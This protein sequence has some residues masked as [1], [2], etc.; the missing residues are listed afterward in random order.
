MAEKFSVF[1]A[2]EG[3]YWNYIETRGK[4]PDCFYMNEDMSFM[5]Y[6]EVMMESIQKLEWDEIKR[7]ENLTYRGI[8]IQLT[9]SLYMS[10]IIAM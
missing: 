1:E 5:L 9:D 10:E 3:H 4:E 7:A 6:N 8:R 2:L